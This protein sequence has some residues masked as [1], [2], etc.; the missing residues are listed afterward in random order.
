MLIPGPPAISSNYLQVRVAGE[1]PPNRMLSVST[2]TIPGAHYLNAQ[3]ET[4]A[5]F[6]V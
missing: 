6:A 5:A 2:I 4:A 1:F 3:P